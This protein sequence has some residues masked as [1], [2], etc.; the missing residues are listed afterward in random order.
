MVFSKVYISNHTMQ[1]SSFRNYPHYSKVQDKAL[2]LFSRPMRNGR[3]R[4]PH[5]YELR[6]RDGWEAENGTSGTGLSTEIRR[7]K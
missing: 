6:P 5:L 7:R 2:Q 3:K 4:S 1:K